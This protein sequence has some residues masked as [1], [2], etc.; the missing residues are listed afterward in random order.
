MHV[1]TMMITVLLLP[2]SR[3][4]QHASASSYL[5]PSLDCMIIQNADLVF[6]LGSVIITHHIV[7]LCH[8][9]Q[10]RGDVPLHLLPCL[11]L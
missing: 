9:Y 8:L 5:Y 6:V 1:T 11:L 3:Y 2:L 10:G 4:R 7:L